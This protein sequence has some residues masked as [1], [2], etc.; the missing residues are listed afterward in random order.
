MVPH[1]SIEQA[2]IFCSRIIY[3]CIAEPFRTT[4]WLGTSELVPSGGPKAKF[5][6]GQRAQQF[7]QSLSLISLFWS[8]LKKSCCIQLINLLTLLLL[9]SCRLTLF[10]SCFGSVC[11]CPLVRYGGICFYKGQVDKTVCEAS[12]FHHNQRWPKD[13]S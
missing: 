1:P 6:S 10:T 13:S 5:A 3:N 7:T 2:C 12:R 8:F 9:E 11:F 4:V